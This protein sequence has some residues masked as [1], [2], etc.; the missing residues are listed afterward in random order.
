LQGKSI[1]FPGDAGPL[2]RVA[3]VKE[4]QRELA[5][6]YRR[7]TKA[8]VNRPLMNYASAREAPLEE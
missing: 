8:D 2:A 5:R 6:K 3:K 4:K 1:G 7:P